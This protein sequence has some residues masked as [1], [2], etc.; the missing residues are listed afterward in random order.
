MFKN[1]KSQQKIPFY[2]TVKVA[3]MTHKGIETSVD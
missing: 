2:D 3:K 1:L